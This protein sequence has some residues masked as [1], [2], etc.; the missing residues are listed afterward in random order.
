MWQSGGSQDEP[1]PDC[2]W[3][4]IVPIETVTTNAAWSFLRMA[5]SYGKSAVHAIVTCSMS[6]LA[7]THCAMRGSWI[8]AVVVAVITACSGSRGS[9]EGDGTDGGATDDGGGGGTF[10][11][12][13]GGGDASGPDTGTTTTTTIYANTDDTLYALDPATNALTSIGKFVNND[14]AVTDCAV[15]GAG[16]VFFSTIIAIYRATLPASGTGDVVLSKVATIGAK[17]NQ[18]FYALAFAPA[19]VLGPT[20]A[21][22]GGDGNGELWFIDQA[23]GATKDLGGFGPDKSNVFALSGDIVF[24]T[25]AGK[26]TGMA[27]IRSCQTPGNNCTSSNDY[28]AGIDIGALTTAFTS[29]TPAKSLLSGIYG[30]SASGKGAGIGHGEI[31][32]LGAWEGNVYGFQRASANKGVPAMLAID[33]GTGAGNAMPTTGSFTNGWSGA[34]VTTK[35]TVN[36]PPPP[37]PP[38]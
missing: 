5:R 19:G 20:E 6:H 18:R 2:L 24:Y 9:F 10:D 17:A 29:G 37:P 34:C 4:A 12:D 21:L 36:V 22:V 28:L 14:S 3:H 31:Y 11:K 25:Q 7:L 33:T 15:N 38:S 13:S 8:V 30:G 23:T 32:G 35:V 16:D 1:P 27:T 26:P